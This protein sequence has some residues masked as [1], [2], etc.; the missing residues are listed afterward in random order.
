MIKTNNNEIN[1][2]WRLPEQC[3][4]QYMNKLL[5]NETFSTSFFIPFI[6][7]FVDVTPLFGQIRAEAEEFRQKRH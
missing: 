6:V 3:I 4:S 1:I 5:I 7:M 2:S